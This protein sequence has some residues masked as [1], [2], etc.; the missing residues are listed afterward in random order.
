MLRVYGF[1][2]LTLCSVLTLCSLPWPEPFGS[3]VLDLL[4]SGGLQDGSLGGDG[5]SMVKNICTHTNQT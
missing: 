4:D 1:W 2:D 5:L 3:S